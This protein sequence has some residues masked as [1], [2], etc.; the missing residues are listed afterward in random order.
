M[1]VV[2]HDD[3]RVEADTRRPAMDGHGEPRG[4]STG[5]V[6][7]DLASLDPAE[8][9]LAVTRADGDVDRARA[10]VIVSR[11]AETFAAWR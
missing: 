7:A 6:E 10:S 11:I 2:G 3:V 1:N 9:A 4:L 5:R 8:K